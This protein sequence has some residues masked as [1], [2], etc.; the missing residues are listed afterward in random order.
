MGGQQKRKMPM[1]SGD[2]PH[3]EVVDP[4]RLDKDAASMCGP[5]KKFHDAEQAEIFA[6]C[7]SGRSEEMEETGETEETELRMPW[8]V[9]P[10]LDWTMEQCQPEEL[11]QDC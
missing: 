1:Q 11:F 3:H 5:A 2:M 6:V 4:L 10:V 8:G 9:E 7:D